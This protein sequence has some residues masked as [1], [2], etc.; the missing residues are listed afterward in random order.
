MSLHLIGQQEKEREKQN[1]MIILTGG[2]QRKRRLQQMRTV[3]AQNKHF[4]FKQTHTLACQRRNQLSS[5]PS[6]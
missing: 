3:D 4:F 1:I 5:Q 6:E 2:N